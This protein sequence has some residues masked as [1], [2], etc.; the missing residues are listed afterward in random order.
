MLDQK[1][2]HPQ[3]NLVFRWHNMVGKTWRY[4]V[5]CSMLARCWSDL[6]FFW[7]FTALYVLVLIDL[8]STQSHISKANTQ[9]PCAMLVRCWSDLTSFW[10]F[11]ALYFLVLIDLNCKHSTQSHISKA[12][13]QNPCAVLARCWSNLTFFCSLLLF[14]FFAIDWFEPFG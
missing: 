12:N 3:M 4:P 2:L 5:V 8:H 14:V 9:N 7:Q 6:T 13:T 10:Q 1:W 11:T